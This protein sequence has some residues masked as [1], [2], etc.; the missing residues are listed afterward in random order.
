MG[1]SRPGSGYLGRELQELRQTRIGEARM[2][3][4]LLQEWSTSAGV[5]E[6]FWRRGAVLQEEVGVLMTS[7]VTSGVNSP[8]TWLKFTQQ[9]LRRTSITKGKG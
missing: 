8:E 1:G 6:F 4:Q 3:V 7:V 2:R 5:L 9:L